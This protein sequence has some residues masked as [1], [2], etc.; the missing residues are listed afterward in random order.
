MLLRR[1]SDGN[2]ITLNPNCSLGAGGEA[3]IFAIPQYPGLVAKIYHN[4]TIER[5]KKLSVM[6]ANP[7]DDPMASLGHVSIA[8]PLD[9]LYSTN[10][11]NHATGFIMPLVKDMRPI[12]DFYNPRSR[13]RHCPLF[14]YLYLHRS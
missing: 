2:Y 5:T 7:P 9:L 8:W 1:H 11:G 13:R 3:H 6:I 14:N 10:N 12:F 4:P